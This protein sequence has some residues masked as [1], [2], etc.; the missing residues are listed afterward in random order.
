MITKVSV[1]EG[2]KKLAEE[3]R[4]AEQQKRE[5]A[6]KRREEAQVWSSR[7]SEVSQDLAPE[8]LHN[9]VC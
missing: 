1:I 3:R 5:E 8:K 4:K 7:V 9:D 2:Q 6:K